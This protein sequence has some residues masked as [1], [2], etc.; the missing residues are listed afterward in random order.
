MAKI[1]PFKA[2]RPTRDK[3]HLAAA[4]SYISYSKNSLHQKLSK[5]PFSFL[6]VINPEYKN[7]EISLFNSIPGLHSIKNKFYNFCDDSIYVQDDKPCLY[8]YRQIKN[9]QEYTGLIGCISI[10]DYKEGIIKKHEATISKR[11]EKLKT[12]LKVVNINAEPVCMT[13][14]RSED[15]AY[16]V[17]KVTSDRA[18]YDFSTVDGVRHMFWIIALEMDIEQ[19]Q[20]YFTKIPK[21]YIADGHHRSASSFLLGRE[22]RKELKNF[23]GKEGFNYFMG[24]FFSEDNISIMQFSRL[25]KDLNGMSS[26]EFIERLKVDFTV[27]KKGKKIHKPL[28]L[29]DISMYL[30]GKWYSLHPKDDS[31]DPLHPSGHL[32]TAILTKNILEPILGIKD[33]RNNNRMSYLGGVKDLKHIKREVDKGKMRVA[34]ALFPVTIEQLKNIADTGDVMPPKS[35]WIEPKLMTGLTIYNL[36]DNNDE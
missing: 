5:N 22:K 24:I 28:E 34:F 11:E 3:A 36:E 25:V 18:E 17:R 14:P 2:F 33:S 8:I 15:V 27:S 23:T 29:H 26:E 35:T 10:D 12:Y 13:Y 19:I 6:H 1:I 9:G 30:D 16:V 7:K 31:F 4:R 20:R 32:D 21:V